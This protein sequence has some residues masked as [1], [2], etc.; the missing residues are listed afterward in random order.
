MEQQISHIGVMKWEP[1]LPPYAEQKMNRA[2]P[3]K[4]C[5]IC[6]AIKLPKF[7]RCSTGCVTPV[8]HPLQLR[9]I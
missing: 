7:N 6:R 3:I 4:V 9:T 8:V 5:D 1:E 2:S